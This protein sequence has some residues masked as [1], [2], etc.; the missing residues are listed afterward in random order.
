MAAMFNGT[1]AATPRIDLGDLP[2]HH[3]HDKTRER[4]EMKIECS[5]HAPSRNV[6]PHRSCS[7]HEQLHYAD[8]GGSRTDGT[9]P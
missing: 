4:P 6:E 5:E 9:K 3:G 8:G 2:I 7:P 1:A